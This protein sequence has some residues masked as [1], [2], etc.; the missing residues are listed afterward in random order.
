MPVAGKYDICDAIKAMGYYAEKTGRRVTFEY[1]MIHGENDSDEDA[2]RLSDLVGNI[3]CL[4]NLIPV[5][6]VRERSFVRPDHTHISSFQKKLENYGINVTIRREL[7]RDIDGA[8]GQLRRRHM[9]G[10]E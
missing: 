10:Q 9:K 3:M 5:N 6:P 2:K 1:S 7:G 8:C 4:V